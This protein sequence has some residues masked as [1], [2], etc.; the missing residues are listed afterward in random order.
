MDSNYQYIPFPVPEYLAQFLAFKLHT[1]IRKQHGLT[2]INVTRHAELG[3]MIL[4]HLSKDP[5]RVSKKTEGVFFLK[6]SNYAGNNMPEVPR[7]DRHLLRLEPASQDKLI[8]HLKND[9]EENLLHYVQGA[10]FAHKMNGW[11]PAQKRKGIRKHAI[12]EFC[13][14]NRVSP[15]K[16]SFDSLFKMIQRRMNAP[17]SPKIKGLQNVVLALSF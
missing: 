10:E 7:G 6:I 8:D 17:K 11:T 12:N 2:C 4:G 5:R 1:K 9:F 13:K 3:K 16:R 15:D 14:K